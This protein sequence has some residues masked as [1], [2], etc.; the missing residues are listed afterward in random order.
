[1]I[2]R[3]RALG[4]VISHSPVSSCIHTGLLAE[5]DVDV[6]DVVAWVD[7]GRKFPAKNGP[8]PAQ[9]RV[10]FCPTRTRGTRPAIP[11]GLCG[12]LNQCCSPRLRIAQTRRPMG[13]RTRVAVCAVSLG[14]AAVLALY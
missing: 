12:C 8:K 7:M 1:M 13:R 5:S 6:P 11:S 14:F 9:A 10:R 4:R 2:L 3:W